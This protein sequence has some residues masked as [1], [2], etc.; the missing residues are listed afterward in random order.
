MLTG[1][2]AARTTWHW[3]D[4]FFARNEPRRRARRTAQAP[5]S[6]RISPCGTADR[7][8]Y[9]RPPCRV[10]VLLPCCPSPPWR[11]PSPPPPRSPRT[12]GPGPTCP[13]G[14]SAGRRRPLGPDAR[15]RPGA[16]GARARP[17][18]QRD[19]M[20]GAA[21]KPW[22]LKAAD[23]KLTFDALTTAKRAIRAKAPG[24]VG[25][26]L[27]HSRLAVALRGSPAWRPRSASR[28]KQRDGQDHAQAH[29]PHPRQARPGARPEGRRR[30]SRRG[31]RR[32]RHRAAHA[33]HRAEEDLAGGQRQRPQAKSTARSSRSTRPTSSCASSRASSSRSPTGWPSA[34]RPTRRRP[35]SSTIANKQVDPVWSVPNSPWAGELQGTTVDGGSAANPLKARW[36]GIANGVGIHGTGEDYSI[37]SARVS[38]LHPHARGRREGPVPARPGRDVGADQVG[39]RASLAPDARGVWPRVR[40]VCLSAPRRAS[41]VG[42]SRRWL[43]VRVRPG[44][45]DR[46]LCRLTPDMRGADDT[47]RLFGH[48]SWI[49]VASW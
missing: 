20:L 2:S 6:R 27:S 4:E 49:R 47:D 8:R 12:Q 34:S 17:E 14:V 11:R 28:A 1:R 35:A 33:A 30:P 31:A 38:R 5:P 19:L 21:G 22:T 24:D 42:G 43:V 32:R 26:K 40:S 15:R 37:G 18:G 9:P 48:E 7:R 3:I 36:M 25:L 13:P 44:G 16:P 23:A 29:L 46:G 45:W 41:G 10:P 39:V